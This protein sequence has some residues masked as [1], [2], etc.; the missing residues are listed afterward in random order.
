MDSWRRVCSASECCLR[1]PRDKVLCSGFEADNQLAIGC[2]HCALSFAQLVTCLQ[3]FIA[4]HTTRMPPLPAVSHHAAVEA[5]SRNAAGRKTR[6]LVPDRE[7]AALLGVLAKGVSYKLSPGQA[8]GSEPTPKGNTI[9]TQ[10]RLLNEGYGPGTPA[11]SPR[12][13]FYPRDPT[14]DIL[15][16]AGGRTCTGE[17]R[18]FTL[19]SKAGNKQERPHLICPEYTRR[20]S[21]DAAAFRPAA[22][23]ST[24]VVSR[25]SYLP[26]IIFSQ[27]EDLRFVRALTCPSPRW[28]VLP[29]R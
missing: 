20:R 4:P 24:L 22:T 5:D 10:H 14:I 29:R 6:P 23:I 21:A 25:L 18:S 26:P 19:K 13:P 15:L 3:G 9:L 16:K 27:P 2:G 28:C 11:G 17:R 12:Q 1:R 7:M 8:I